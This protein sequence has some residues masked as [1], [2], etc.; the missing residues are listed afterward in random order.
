MPDRDVRLL[1]GL[2]ATP[3][4]YARALLPKKSGTSLPRTLAMVRDHRQDRAKLAAYNAVCGFG[5][6]DQVPATW[7]HVQAFP[8]QLEILAAHDFPFSM[9]SV[10]HAS[11][12]MTLHRPVSAGEVLTLTAEAAA[13][14]PHR[15]GVVVELTSRALVEDEEVWTG[16][17]AYLAMGATLPGL[18]PVTDEPETIGRTELPTVGTWRLP[19]NL[20][21]RY[22]GVSGDVNPIHLNALAAK[23]LGFPRAIIHGMWTHARILAA[24]SPRLPEAYTV[25][26]AFRKPILLPSTVRFAARRAEGGFD[27]AVTSRDGAKD[28]VTATVRPA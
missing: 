1:T 3:G 6:T 22:A 18:A 20:G 15:R 26:V 16:T 4:L 2:P 11:N 21:R 8:L 27:A 12:T 7:L 24:L 10:V 25:D 9:A 19:A 13:A 17:S 14:R 28:F 5:L 23:A